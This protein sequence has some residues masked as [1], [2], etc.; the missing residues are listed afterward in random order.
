MTEESSRALRTF[1]I[2]AL[3]LGLT[4]S[5]YVRAATFGGF[6]LLYFTCDAPLGIAVGS[7][8]P[9][10][11]S[12]LP[13]VFWTLGIIILLGLLFELA[14]AALHVGV[15]GSGSPTHAA[16]ITAYISFSWRFIALAFIGYHLR[17]N[18]WQVATHSLYLEDVNGKLSRELS[19][20]TSLGLPLIA[21]GYLLGFASVCFHL[22]E[23]LRTAWLRVP[24][25]RYSHLPAIL[26]VFVS[27]LGVALFL[28]AANSVLDL[29]TGAS[30]LH[31]LR[32]AW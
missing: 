5:P 13:L 12:E 20:V 31:H 32:P 24:E 14:Y 15:D 7:E 1:K 4:L 8:L 11:G 16:R 10:R 30:L 22:N 3:R 6:L 26:R 21:L 27:A 28:V 19:S 29:A 9:R 2:E 23:A 25:G 18:W 17:H